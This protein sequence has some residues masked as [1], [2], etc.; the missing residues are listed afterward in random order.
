M[1]N[2]NTMKTKYSLIVVNYEC[3][4]YILKMILSLD[5][6]V[7]GRKDYEI[8]IVDNSSQYTDF[9]D[10][11]DN[12]TIRY[13]K[14]ERNVGFGAACNIGVKNAFGEILLFVNPDIIFLKNILSALDDYSDYLSDGN[15][16]G[17]NFVDELGNPTYTHGNFPSLKGEILELLF[18]HKLW[19]KYFSNYTIGKIEAPS[20]KGALD[21]DYV[22]GGLFA[23]S[24]KY[25]EEMN[26]FDESFFLYFEET[27]LMWRFK[28]RGK[29]I[30]LLLDCFAIH[31]GSVTTSIDSD[32]KIINMEIGRANYYKLTLQDNKLKLLSYCSI[33]MIK[34]IIMAIANNK[35]T[36]LDLIGVMRDVIFD[37]KS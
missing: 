21:V 11:V 34:L 28:M 20:N 31:I 32:F 29:K 27:E 2:K 23:T 35:K 30:S 8:I 16:L 9:I 6:C 19:P 17:F 22:C 25:Y 18:V 33:R 10:V 5:R 24:R 3:S 12:S 14:S 26:G 13:I 4:N 36:Y 7:N 15:I 1:I 37:E